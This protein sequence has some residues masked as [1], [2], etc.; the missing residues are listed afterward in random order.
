MREKDEQ[1]MPALS[2]DRLTFL[3]DP[4]VRLMTHEAAFKSALLAQAQVQP[5]QRMLDLACGTA[6]LTIAIKQAQPQAT[7]VGLD[8]DPAILWRA[9]EGVEAQLDEGLSYELPYTDESF[10]RS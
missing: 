3:Y 10:D 4:V 6:T 9:R 1:Y 2:Y 7:V 8:G 5:G